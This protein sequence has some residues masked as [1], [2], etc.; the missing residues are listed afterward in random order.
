M[1]F[2]AGLYGAEAAA[3]R[4]LRQA[5]PRAHG[6]RGGAARRPRE[7]AVHVGARRVN[8]ER[9]V[10][11]RNVVLQAMRENGDIDQADVRSRARDSAGDAARRAAPRRAVRPVLQGAGAAGAGRALRP[12]T[13]LPGRPARLHDHRRRDA[14]GGRGRRRAGRSTISSAPG[15]RPRSRPGGA[16]IRT[17]TPPLQA[18]LVAL[19]PRTGEVRA[20]VGGRSFTESHFNRAVQARRQPGSAF[21][22]FVYAAALEAGY[23][24]ASLIDRPR[25]AVR[26]AA[27]RL[28]ARG[29]ARRAASELTMRTALQDVEQSRRRAHARDGRRLQRRWT[30]RRSSGWDRCPRC[31]RWRSAPA[32]SR[33]ST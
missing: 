18:A 6:G 16:P 26:D 31:R 19:D 5:G 1:Y 30:T 32:R 15:A 11:R 24:P 33:C 25:R 8:M 28:V 10:A 9:A 2:G 21:K 12:R 3:L 22:P 20:I 29:R 14:E 27:G 4:L 13:R 23:T 17:T 7:V